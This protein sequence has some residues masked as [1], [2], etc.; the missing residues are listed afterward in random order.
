MAETGLSLDAQRARIEAWCAASGS[1][2]A[3][4]VED[5]GVSGAKRLRDRPG[6]SRVA[7][8]I[9]SRNPSVSAVVVVRLDRLGRDA[10]E[11]AGPSGLMTQPRCW[12]R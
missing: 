9:D 12:A 6:G 1:T 11:A 10:A 7:D 4:L 8:L 2:L 5:K 3:E